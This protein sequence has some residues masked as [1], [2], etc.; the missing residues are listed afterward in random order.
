[1]AS[2]TSIAIMIAAATTVAAAAA[3]QEPMSELS[4]IAV[5]AGFGTLGGVIATLIEKGA[6]TVRELLLRMLASTL[7]AIAM[8]GG[9]FIWTAAVP[10]Y[11]AVF[12][13]SSAAGLVAWHVVLMVPKIVPAAIREAMKR[14]TGAS[15]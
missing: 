14:A 9:Y 10:T 11:M 4:V 13:L 2:E 12:A 15:T 1:M 8:V 5:S 6:I 7:A 3:P